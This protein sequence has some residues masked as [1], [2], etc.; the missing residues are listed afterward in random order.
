MNRKTLVLAALVTG[1]VTA[2]VAREARAVFEITAEMQKELDRQTQQIKGWAADPVIVRAL[3]W[4]NEKGPIAGMDNEKW[5]TVRRSDDLH[6]SFLNSDAGKLLS[7]KLESSGGVY[8]RAYL[9][10]AR[11]EAFVSTEK[12]SR[13]LNMGQPGFDIPFSTALPWQGPAELDVFSETND[14]HIAVP[15]LSSGRAIGVLTV[16][17]DLG[18]L[19]KKAGK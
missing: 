2:L 14:I 18:K 9:C 15:V 4:E 6:R 7:K 11:G 5:K 13:Y 1:L 17:L 19:A 3:I 16:G 12:T 8:L 10:A